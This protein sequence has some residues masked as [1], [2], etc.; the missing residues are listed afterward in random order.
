MAA[1]RVMGTLI[2]VVK[3]AVLAAVPVR[4]ELARHKE[5]VD[6][7]RHT[8]TLVEERNEATA[9]MMEERERELAAMKRELAAVK[10]EMA[11]HEGRWAEIFLGGGEEGGAGVE[12]TTCPGGVGSL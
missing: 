4:E 5:E 6:E 3:E 2:D 9:A 1:E 7:L 8:L 12:S 10:V 11:K